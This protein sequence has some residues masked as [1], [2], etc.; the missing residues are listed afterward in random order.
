MYP[1]LEGLRVV[2]GS[3]FVAAPSCGMHLAQLGAEVIRFDLIGGGPDFNRWPRSGAGA[4]FFWEGLNKGK[5]SVALDLRRAEGREIAVN[6]ITAPGPNAGVFVTNFPVDGF[7][8]HDRLAQIRPD[9]ITLRIMGHADGRQAV[10]Y[11]VNAALG[12]PYMTGSE[13][14]GDAPVNHVL[15]AWDLL[16][17]A[18]AVFSVLAAERLRRDT[19]QGQELR[20]PLSDIAMTTLGHLGQ[21]AEVLEAGQSRPR[22]GNALFGAFG[23]DFVTADGKRIMLVA[24]TEGQWKSLV[25]ALNI[26]QDVSALEAELS[27]SFA[28]DEGVRFAHKEQL[29][30]LVAPVIAAHPFVEME[31]NLEAHGVCWS[32]Y[33]TMGEALAENPDFSTQNPVFTQVQ[34]PGGYS[35]PTPGFAT[36][37]TGLTREK[38]ARAPRLGEHTEEVLAQVLGLPEHE[39]ASLHDR[40]IVAS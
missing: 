30:A 34:H 10:D 38:P 16:A 40:G 1:V 13:T 31:A 39:I 33:R 2:E 28:R 32:L 35:Y 4:S 14:L 22:Y 26:A 5:K 8:A 25:K 23:R 12:L 19:G 36:T 29:F 9:L 18:H 17:G 27:V 20:L 6:L 7:L 37:F 15:P 21:I 11:T 24:I 3:S